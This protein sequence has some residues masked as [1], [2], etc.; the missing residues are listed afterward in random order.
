VKN[1]YGSKRFK[2]RV[3]DTGFIDEQPKN[4]ILALTTDGFAPFKKSAVS[5]WPINLI[6]STAYFAIKSA[7]KSAAKSTVKSAVK[8]V[9]KLPFFFFF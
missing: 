2:Q 9:V 7:I 5:M 1:L 4:L 3:I 6:V 8:C